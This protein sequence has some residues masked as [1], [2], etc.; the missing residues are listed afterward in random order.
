MMKL[1]LDRFTNPATKAVTS[2]SELPI[3]EPAVKQFVVPGPTHTPPYD[4]VEQLGKMFD[5]SR[6]AAQST[7]DQI[8]EYV[9][10]LHAAQ[11]A[12]APQAPTMDPYGG[13]TKDGAIASAAGVALAHALGV[14]SQFIGQALGNYAQSAKNVSDV[15]YKNALAGYQQQVDRQKTTEA[16]LQNI[17]KSLTT[18]YGQ[19]VKDSSGVLRQAVDAQGD[20]LKFESDMSKTPAEKAREVADMY[21]RLTGDADGAMRVAFSQQSQQIASALNLGSMADERNKMFPA[22]YSE[23]QSRDLKNRADAQRSEAQARMYDTLS[24][25]KPQELGNAMQRH[26]DEMAVEW[27]KFN[28]GVY[29]AENG[30]DGSGGNS[31]EFTNTF[32][33]KVLMARSFLTVV[34][35]QKAKLSG[36]IDALKKQGKM[37]EA[38]Q[39]QAVLDELVQKEALFT[40][41]VRRFDA[42]M[43]GGGTM[44][45]SG[46]SMLSPI[47]IPLQGPIGNGSLAPLRSQKISFDEWNAS[48]KVGTASASPPKTTKPK[49]TSS[50]KP[51]TKKVAP[52]AAKPKAAP[53]VKQAKKANAPVN[54]LID[55]LVKGRR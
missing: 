16:G 15:R 45:T 9:S 53:A 42:S 47:E 35:Q 18:Q 8:A 30:T 39:Q 38:A 5:E 13:M 43:S 6:Q 19:D 37:V 54:P 26:A 41:M 10:K 32:K 44:T 7:R 29:K 49:K 48:R 3:Q 51:S 28:L 27:A 21:Y 46:G 11:Q 20:A 55:A 36:E 34:G 23:A 50:K 24:R 31:S 2:A 1:M 17:I 22:K 40:E 14:R 33:E 12:P 25:L 52:K 4:M